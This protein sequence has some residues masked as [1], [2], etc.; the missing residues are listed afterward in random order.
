M[1]YL[2]IAALGALG[3]PAVADGWS[4]RIGD[5]A[6]TA[7][8][9][10]VLTTDSTLTYYDDGQSRYYADGRYAWVYSA[11][12]GGASIPGRFEVRDDGAVC[13]EFDSGRARCDL[14][15]RAGGRLVLITEAG[16]RFPVRN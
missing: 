6:L 3:S 8:E 16:D 11:E 10:Q 12:N 5:T 9:A 7:S 13:V 1:R 4:L 15:V 14:F 2:V